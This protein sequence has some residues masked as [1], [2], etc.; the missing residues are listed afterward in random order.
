MNIP[1]W[2]MHGAGNDFIL[3]NAMRDPLM[4]TASVIADWCR[5]HTGVG[6]EGV[7]LLRP[8]RASGHFF[9]QF[10]NPDGGE[11]E[12]CGNGARCAARLAC[13][14]KIAPPAMRIET[15]A[16][17]HQ[18]EVLPD[19][20]GVRLE[21]PPPTDCRINCTL[22]MEGQSLL[23]YSFANTG[24]PHV[25]IEHEDLDHL[26]IGTLGAT[27]RH[28]PCFA[29]RG[30]NVNFVR[31]I[32][33][34]TL[35]I[36]TYERGVEAETLACGTGVAAAAVTAVL[37]GRVI[38]PVTVCTAGGDRLLVAV[39]V[40]AGVLGPIILTG[41]AVYVFTGTLPADTLQE[42]PPS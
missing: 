2:K 11:V 29:P 12:M 16:G 13:D 1:F 37:R 3:I 30:T 23:R 33:L 22:E 34:D 39:A 42:E 7:I 17:I 36:R 19:E 27:I 20:S 6:A 18:A 38:S 40:Y 10:F 15:A 9:M 5:R 31:I 26:P 24:V 28:H 8:P 25:V 32:G 4:L 21:L 14:L 41:P 35:R